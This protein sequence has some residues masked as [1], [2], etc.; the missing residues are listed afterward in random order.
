M[1]ILLEIHLFILLQ[2]HI[3]F[4]EVKQI[5][6]ILELLGSGKDSEEFA[7][8]A[9]FRVDGH[10]DEVA[11][12][13][14]FRRELESVGCGAEEILLADRIFLSICTEILHKFVICSTCLEKGIGAFRHR[15]VADNDRPRITF[16]RRNIHHCTLSAVRLRI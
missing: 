10:A 4:N 7:T 8:G 1:V 15:T 14:V 6:D 16:D 2:N 11:G 5:I 9:V 3:L 13:A 12:Q